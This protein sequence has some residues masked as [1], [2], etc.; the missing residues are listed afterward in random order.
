MCSAERLSYVFPRVKEFGLLDVL[1][2]VW[3]TGVPQHHPISEYTDER[4][5][6]WRENFVYR[7]PTGEVVAVYEDITQRKQTE[8]AL[9]R[10]E[11]RYRRLFTSIRDAILVTDTNRKIIDCNPAFTELFGYTLEEIRGRQPG[12]LYADPGKDQEMA[13][14]LSTSSSP[15]F[16]CTL[17]YKTKDGQ[18]FPGET[19][20]FFL[21]KDAGEVAGR[22]GLIRDVSEREKNRAEKERLETQLRQAQKMEAVGRL[23]GGVAHDFNNLLTTITGNAQIGLMDLTPDQELYSILQEI[24]EAGEKAGHLTRQLLAFS[25]KQILQPEVLDLNNLILELEKMLRRLIGE[26]I[27]LETR[28]MPGLKPIKADPGQMEQAIL[29]LVIN[30]RDAMPSGG[31]VTIETANPEPDQSASPDDALPHTAQS[32]VMLAISDTG[33]GMSP[34]TQSQIFDPFFTTKEKGQGTGLGLSTVYGVI[35]QSKGTIR[36]QSAPGQGTTFTIFLPVAQDPEPEANAGPAVSP[37]LHGR[38]VI[39]VVEDEPSVREI[40]ASSLRRFGYT[41]LTAGSGPEAL[42]LC[43]KRRK[44]IDLV[45]TDV[46]MPEMN[47]R[48]LVESIQA[49]GAN[50]QVIYMSGYTEN[51]VLGHEGLDTTVCFLQKPFSAQALAAKVR[52][53]LRS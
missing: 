53:A 21:H 22:I 39:L 4:I 43:K 10:S 8:L 31:R 19:N 52:E 40:V 28:L 3:R 24:Q 33:Q 36:V 26:H 49:L 29:N 37:D 32:W 46:V 35:Q 50:I 38:K 6:G 13:K 14:Q 25:R 23:A 45:L 18:I 1:R 7:L 12:L 17:E 11:S 47:G 9:K 2:Q 42:E 5:T 16:I 15:R 44:E 48:E 20:I 30:A 27:T 34:Q 51:V 41:V